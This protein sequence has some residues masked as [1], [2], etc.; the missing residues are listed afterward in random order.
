[1][2]ANHSTNDLFEQVSTLALELSTFANTVYDL[3]GM[4]RNAPQWPWLVL[5]HSERLSAAIDRLGER[6]K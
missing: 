2:A 1:M 5:C 6:L 4:D 3:A